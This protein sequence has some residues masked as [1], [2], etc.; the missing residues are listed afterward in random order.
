[1]ATLRN[2]GDV[3]ES[4]AAVNTTSSTLLATSATSAVAAIPTK[5]DGDTPRYVRL[6]STQA[7]YVN[8]GRKALALS[9]VVSA[10]GSGYA[11]A[12]TITITGGTAT[13]NAVFNVAT[14]KLASAS[15]NAAGT[16]YAPGNT[17][18]LAGG[19]SSAKAVLTVSTTKVVS[20]TVYESGSEGS[21]GAVTVA[22][23]TGTGTKFHASVTIGGDGA[24]ESVDGISL[25]GS[26]TVNPTNI[27]NEPVTG[28]GLVDAALSV[29]LGIDT[30]TVSTAGSY[31]ANSSTFTQFATS[32]SGTGATF[33]TASYGVNTLTLNNAGSYSVL[34]SNPAAQGSTSGV[35]S[36]ATLTVT[37]DSTGLVATSSNLRIAGVGDN[38]IID[39]A[40]VTHIAALR[41]SADG[42]LQISP[43]ENR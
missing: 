29:V 5:A 39:V 21:P 22:G 36:G 43:I 3:T 15:L 33:N 35:G 24:I 20:A 8:V 1:M 14:T 38:P 37:Y 25:A 28:S 12:D 23:T 11:P 41:V 2:G 13:T 34:P 17:V 32:G 30:F 9:A 42:S 40:G 7:C 26:Y 16:G 31:T 10:I 4:E 6:S 27:V 18:T 19:T